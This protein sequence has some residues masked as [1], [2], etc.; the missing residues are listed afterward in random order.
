VYMIFNLVALFA[1][2]AVGM[3]GVA[4]GCHVGGFLAG[5][6]MTRV[7]FAGKLEEVS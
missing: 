4:V 2:D 6:L 7:A 3:H 1:P 5:F